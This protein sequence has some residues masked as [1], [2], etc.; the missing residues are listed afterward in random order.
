MN[1]NVRVRATHRSTW[2][3]VGSTTLKPE[4]PVIASFSR[5]WTPVDSS[6]CDSIRVT[7]KSTTACSRQRSTGLGRLREMARHPSQ[8]RHLSLCRAHPRWVAGTDR[9]NPP[10]PR[11]A[12]PPRTASPPSPV[13]MCLTPRKLPAVG[14]PHRHS[15]YGRSPKTAVSPAAV[16]RANRSRLPDKC[17][18]GSGCEAAMAVQHCVPVGRPLR[19]S[20]C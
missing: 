20:S 5:A 1:C 13:A 17:R 10:E 4:L 3:P 19:W 12:P 7:H 15:G 18:Y 9:R 11:T 2:S 16:G 6:H 8:C 14:C